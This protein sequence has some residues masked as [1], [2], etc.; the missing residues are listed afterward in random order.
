MITLLGGKKK[1][2][3]LKLAN[4]YALDRSFDWVIYYKDMGKLLK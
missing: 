3:I 1:K 4:K 2:K